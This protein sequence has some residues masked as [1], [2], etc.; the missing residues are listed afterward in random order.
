[1][2][3][4]LLDNSLKYAGDD[5]EI[6][7]ITEH[8]PSGISLSVQD[9]GPGI[10]DEYREQVF[11]KFFRIPD[12]NKHKV[13]GYGMGLN[14]ASQVMERHSGSIAYSNLPGGGCRFTLQ[15]PETEE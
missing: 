14:F 5:P 12:G 8:L 2:I 13:K 7:I 11:E 6:L 3:I 1:V 15:F 10:P 9:K 4:N